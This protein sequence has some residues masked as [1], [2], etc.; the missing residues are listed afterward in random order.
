MSDVKT[1]EKKMSAKKSKRC[2]YC[3]KK[4]NMIHF[5]CKCDLKILCTVCLPSNV[6]QCRVNYYLI[7]QEQLRRDN[8]VVIAPKFE[9]V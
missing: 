9:T 8:P 2:E 4:V 5:E 6:H 7:H 3:G 1:T